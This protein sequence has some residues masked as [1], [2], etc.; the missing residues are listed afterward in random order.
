M[1]RDDCFTVDNQPPRRLYDP[2]NKQFL[3]SLM[4]NQCPRELEPKDMDEIHFFEFG[5]E[6]YLKE[7]SLSLA[8]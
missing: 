6:E 5:K 7:P 4:N 2:A 3:E 8:E 1:L